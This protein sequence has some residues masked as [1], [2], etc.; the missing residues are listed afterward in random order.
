MRKA[1]ARMLQRQDP[2]EHAK[3][4]S[5]R[6]IFGCMQNR[7][8]PTT[9]TAGIDAS[10]AAPAP[11]TQPQDPTGGFPQAPRSSPKA[12]LGAS[13]KKA[14]RA[15]VC[16]REPQTCFS[17][18][19]RCHESLR[20]QAPRAGAREVALPMATN[21]W[22]PRQHRCRRL[23]LGRLRLHRL[24]PFPLRAPDARR[25]VADQWRGVAD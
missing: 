25:G 8:V 2:T 11:G 12:I 18:E 23:C 15:E 19:T 14:G 22:P 3:I 7:A 21:L 24:P 16:P 20:R 17:S 6:N 1:Y 13:L 4:A 10:D 5:D 9:K